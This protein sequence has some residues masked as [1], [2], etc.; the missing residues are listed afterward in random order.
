[1]TW[2]VSDREIATVTVKGVVIAG[3]RR[4]HAEIRV[5]DSKNI[6]H[7]VVGKV[8]FAHITQTCI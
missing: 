3:K 8:K 6:L 5:S 1:M 7:K 2:E 4:G